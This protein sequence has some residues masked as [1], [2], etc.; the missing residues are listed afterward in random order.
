MKKVFALAVIAAMGL[1]SAAFAADAQATRVTTEKT[2]HHQ[3]HHKAAKKSQ[4][5]KKR[6]KKPG[7]EKTGQPAA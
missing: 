4:T 6:V 1:S 2:V 3:K 5:E 7:Q